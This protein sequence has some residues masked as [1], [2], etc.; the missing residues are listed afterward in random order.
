MGFP[1]IISKP[2]I[3]YNKI[4]N[5]FINLLKGRDL[6]IKY[7]IYYRIFILSYL[8]KVIPIR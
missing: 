6:K 5:L 8:Y 3:N 7:I 4:I 1:K 2:L